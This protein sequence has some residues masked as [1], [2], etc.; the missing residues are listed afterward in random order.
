MTHYCANLFCVFSLDIFNVYVSV[1][2]SPNV[3][4]GTSVTL[5][6]SESSNAIVYQ[7]EWLKGRQIVGN[8]STLTLASIQREDSGRYF[9]RVTA[10]IPNTTRTITWASSEYLYV[11]CKFALSC[12]L[13]KFQFFQKQQI[14]MDYI[15]D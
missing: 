1:T 2:P 6:C 15:M 12:N 5:T 3:I 4:E 8:S 13:F 7:Y 14:F 9:C 10:T 11:K